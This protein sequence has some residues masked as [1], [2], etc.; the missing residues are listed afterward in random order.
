MKAVSIA[1]RIARAFSKKEI[2]LFSGYHG[3]SDWY[4]SANLSNKSELDGQLMPGLEPNGIPR[5]L[6]GTALSFNFNDINSIKEKIIGNE[7]NIAAIILEPARTEMASLE[8]LEELRNLADE[9][10]P[11]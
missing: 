9:I 5:A 2:I 10:E 8:F 6:Q 3:W 11:C 7:N 1:I 4:L